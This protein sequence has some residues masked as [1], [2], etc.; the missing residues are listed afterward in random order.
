MRYLRNFSDFILEGRRSKWDSLSSKITSQIFSQWVAEVNRGRKKSEYSEQIENP[1]IEFDIFATLET[2]GIG[3]EVT[4]RTGANSDDWDKVDEDV[5][6]TPH[7][8]IEFKVKKDWLPEYWSEIYYNLL[9]VVRHEIEHITQGG[10]SIGNYRKGKPFEDDMGYRAMIKEGLLPKHYY[11]LL[12]KEV[13]ANLQGL[14]FE[15]KKRREPMK[16]TV[17]RYLNRQEYLTR[18]TKNQ[19]LESWRKRA[20]KIGGIPRF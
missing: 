20:R 9:D 6:V 10:E 7:I 4:D 13:D 11:L 1:S 15:A 14:R 12:P 18:T 5:A 19:V 2:G 17:K 8:N 16:N 3:F